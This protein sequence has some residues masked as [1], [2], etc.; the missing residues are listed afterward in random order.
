MEG[1]GKRRRVTPKAKA[2]PSQ[3]ELRK[4]QEEKQLKQEKNKRDAALKKV[5]T[6]C[7][8]VAAAIAEDAKINEQLKTGLDYPSFAEHYK[9]K[10]AEV[11]SVRAEVHDRWVSSMALESCAKELQDSTYIQKS[12]KAADEDCALLEQRLKKYK[13]KTALRCT[14]CATSRTQ[15]MR[16]IMKERMSEKRANTKRLAHGAMSRPCAWA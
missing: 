1:P 4:I 9:E 11:E 7:D 14:R 10:M 2:A 5:K 3:E 16:K 15:G 6:A 8:K 13:K 12:I